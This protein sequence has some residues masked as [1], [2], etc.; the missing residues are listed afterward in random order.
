MYFSEYFK[1]ARVNEGF[2]L[3]RSLTL[4]DVDYPYEKE[5]T[6]VLVFKTGRG[7][8]SGTYPSFHTA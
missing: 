7:F 2:A 3:I 5:N 1:G 8:F 6:P 4:I